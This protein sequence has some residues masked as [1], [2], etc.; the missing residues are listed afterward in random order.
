MSKATYILG[1]HGNYFHK[2]TAVHDSNACIV[3][4]GHVVAAIAEER[5]TRKK[6]EG[7]Y[8]DNAI[9]EVLKIA[10][11]SF[12]DIDM[13]AYSTMHPTNANRSALK[14]YF[15]TF[16]DTGVW[17]GK[18]VRKTLKY[19]LSSYR[20]PGNVKFEYEDQKK[21][22][23]F[24]DHHLSHAASAYYTA[25]FDDAIIIT[26]DGGG[27][28]FDGGVYVGK[29]TELTKIWTI[30][31]L[32][33]PCTMYSGL[34]HD[35]GFK[36]LRHEGKL[37]GLAAYGNDDT[38][39]LGIDN[40]VK[41][42]PKKKRFI[43]KLIAKHQKNTLSTSPYFGPKLKD[44]P[45]EDLAAGM[46]KLFEREVLR[47]VSHA[48]EVCKSQGYSCK[49][50]A[51]AGGAFANVK[52]NQRIHQLGLFDDVFI[53]PAMGDDGLSVGAALSCFYQT[54]QTNSKSSSVL[55]AP[56]LGHAY[57]NQEIEAA[58]EKFNLS[59]EK[60]ENIED[61]L[62]QILA[63]SKVV[64][65]F[66]GRMEYGP[67]ALG[68]RSLL[69]SPFDQSINDWLNKQL[70][71]TEFMPFAP[72]ITRERASDFLVDYN[73]G[74]VSAA[75]HMTITYS[76]KDGM[77]EKIPAVV[78]VDNTA[79]PQ[80]VHKEIAPSYHAIINAFEKYSGVPV[81]LNTSFNM[82]EE[83]IVYSPEDAIRGFLDSGVDYLAMEG[84]LVAQAK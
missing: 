19:L 25:P 29:G 8:P 38:E 76:I 39:R 81:V 26:L 9:E 21:P 65:R 10:G 23:Y 66:E 16:K 34:T 67:R 2:A 35:L 11:I 27:D 15:S 37:T 53:F 1:L 72:S 60:P 40:L 14:S 5:L 45:R 6:G 22:L 20:I 54:Q 77:A 64:A 73:D 44:F 31:S 84:Y 12:A 42:D 49:N 4:D 52:M 79:R 41:Y 74:G 57:S 46:Q 28:G 58:L 78:H 55:D 17:H 63:E 71:R 36:R 61:R 51:M 47:F 68:H 50:I 7:S 48:V 62:G 33:S 3:K 30:P 83:P 56:Y 75:N 13:V 18:G 80:I 43:S 69:A 32:Q 82:H 24:N 59:Y 70:K